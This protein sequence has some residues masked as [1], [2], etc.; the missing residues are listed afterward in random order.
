MNSDACNL[1]RYEDNLNVCGVGVVI[2]GAWDVFKAVVQFLTL[3]KNMAGDY[4]D[5]VGAEEKGF[6]VGFLI[7]FIAIVLFVI[8]LIFLL[9]AYVGINASRAAK[10]LPYKKG[11]YVWAILLLVLSVISLVSYVDTIRHLAEIETTVAALIIDLTYIY[12]LGTVIVST[13]RIKALKASQ[14]CEDIRGE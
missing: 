10:R 14:G 9:H 4:F 5:Q 1:R 3:T 12:I 8:A 2:L 11:Y 6:A 13:R 7:V